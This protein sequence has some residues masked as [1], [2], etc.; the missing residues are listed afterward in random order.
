MR[1]FSADTG[2]S[3]VWLEELDSKVISL[4]VD[5]VPPEAVLSAVSR[6]VGAELSK[7]DD[8]YYLG[9]I[10]KTDRVVFVGRVTRIKVADLKDIAEKFRTDL[11]VL[12]VLPDGVCIFADSIDS[13]RQF[14]QLVE[15]L[16]KVDVSV[17]FVQYFLI[18]DSAASSRMR[19]VNITNDL[20]VSAALSGL[21]GAAS[22]LNIS[23]EVSAAFQYELTKSD[24]SI[25]AKPLLLLIDGGSAKI[26]RV[27]SIP[28]AQYTVSDQGAVSVSGY[29][30]VDVGF[31]LETSIRDW[32]SDFASLTYA[33]DIGQV[34]GYVDKVPIQTKDVLSGETI[35][36]RAGTYLLGSFQRHSKSKGRSGLFGFL[37]S[38]ADSLGTIRIWAKVE[39]ISPV[40]GF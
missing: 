39:K 4:T 11:G 8:L 1:Q 34:T 7:Y 29:K 19:G 14:S 28:I 36:K 6:R 35:V 38:D 17:W 31:N 24:V 12:T 37:F 18:Q 5:N 23:G 2:L 13:V 27:E 26:Q 32:G 3:V 25:L 20:T 10:K 9:A 21:S 33:F 16:Q 22:G 40:I 15:K 30:N